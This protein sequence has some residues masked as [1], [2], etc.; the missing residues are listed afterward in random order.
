MVIRYFLYS[1]FRCIDCYKSENS[2]RLRID[3]GG[4]GVIRGTC[5]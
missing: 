1:I 4:L 3:T 2:G 5:M